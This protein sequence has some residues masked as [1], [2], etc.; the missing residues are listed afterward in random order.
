MTFLRLLNCTVNAKKAINTR[1]LLYLTSNDP[2]SLIKNPFHC[3]CQWRCQGCPCEKSRVLRFYLIPPPQIKPFIVFLNTLRE[4]YIKMSK[5]NAPE[6]RRG[7][8]TRGSFGQGVKLL[9]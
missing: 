9:C 5:K 6:V 1:N 8:T 7:K 3:H 4:F 2:E